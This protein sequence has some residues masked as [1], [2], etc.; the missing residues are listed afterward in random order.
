LLSGQSANRAGRQARDWNNDRF[1]EQRGALGGLAFGNSYLDMMGSNLSPE[2]RAQ[3]SQFLGSQGLGNG[4][5]VGAQNRLAG[6]SERQGGNIMQGYNRE[7]RNLAGQSGGN[8]AQVMG[9][10]Q[11]MGQQADQWGRGREDIIRRDAG[12]AN[13]AMDQTSLARLAASGFGNSTAA[14]NQLQGN[15]TATGRAMQDQLQG[16]SEAKIDRQ[17]DIGKAGAAS[18]ER[19]GENQTNRDY[20]RAAGRTDLQLQNLTRNLNMRQ[21]PLNTALGVQQSQIMNP[22][23]SNP[24]GP[25]AGISPLGAAGGTIAGG[26]ASYGGYLQ[27][28]QN[29]ASQNQQ[30]QQLMAMMQ[31][32]GT[33]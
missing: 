22:W 25:G 27:G 10:Y 14:A 5:V 8:L 23:L 2:H 13:K 26:L 1:R 16:L 29:Q 4:G 33:P 7:T 12:T 18:R 15:A 30:L 20:T 19:M 28:Q 17:L 32:Y 9:M 11:G 24:Q 3:L 21:A 6:R 31:G